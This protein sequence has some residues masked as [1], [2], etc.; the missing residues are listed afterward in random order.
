MYVIHATGVND[1]LQKGIELIKTSGKPIDSRNGMTIEVDAP[2]CISY[3]NPRDR[4][5]LNQVRD[6]NPFFHLMESIWIL[7]GRRDVEFLSYFNSRK[8]NYSDDGVTFNAAYGYRMRHRFGLD[9]VATVID[10]LKVDRNTRQAIIQIWDP[11]DLVSAT[12]DKA[13]NTQLIFRVRADGRL[14]MTVYNRSNDM[15]WGAMGANMVQFSMLHEYVA[16]HTDIKIGTYHHIT[17]ALHIYT[18]GPGG[19]LWDK[20]KHIY[21]S[22]SYPNELYNIRMNPKEMVLFDNDITTMFNIMDVTKNPGRCVTALYESDYFKDLID[23]MLYVYY[24]YKE[25]GAKI[26]LSKV[27]KIKS[28]DWQMAASGWLRQRV[29]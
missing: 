5:M 10:L 21:T 8:G 14:D 23:P 11:T 24:T 25:S 29:K 18:D 4:V 13:C 9:Q 17:N 27:Y 19:E 12:L 20:V 28:S 22:L 1:A 15:L 26:A 7:G 6:A 3:I 16:A 2:V